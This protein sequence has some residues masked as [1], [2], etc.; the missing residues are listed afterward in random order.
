MRNLWF[1]KKG[2]NQPEGCKVNYEVEYD[3]ANKVLRLETYATLNAEE[4]RQ[5]MDKIEKEFEGKEQR[6][7]LVDVSA[8]KEGALDREAR[9]TLRGYK[10]Q[11]LSQKVGIIGA[12]PTVRMMAKIALK[13]LGRSETTRFFKREEEALKWFKGEA[14]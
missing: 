4:L 1:D 10:G 9:K 12:N 14:K 13:V 6:Y 3:D 5:I 8:N 2:T 11:S 7:L